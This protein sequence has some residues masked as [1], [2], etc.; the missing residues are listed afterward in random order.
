MK[1]KTIQ[2]H[3]SYMRLLLICLQ[4]MKLYGVLKM[5]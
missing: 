1:L 4:D 2:I 3:T 5:E